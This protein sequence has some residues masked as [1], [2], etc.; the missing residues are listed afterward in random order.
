MCIIC[1][2]TIGSDMSV[3][4]RNNDKAE[5]FLRT[6]TQAQ[7]KMRAAAD[8]LLAVSQ[9]EGLNPEVAKQ[10]DAVHKDMVR[11]RREWNKLEEKRELT[12]PKAN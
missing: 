5:Y 6:F 11:L 9:I 3:I 4:Y 7:D 8:A 1:N 12:T 2:V 10:Y